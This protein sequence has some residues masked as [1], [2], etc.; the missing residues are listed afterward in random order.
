MLIAEYSNLIRVKELI[1]NSPVHLELLE[2]K[3][4]NL[5]LSSTADQPQGLV[6]FAT[7]P[8]LFCRFLEGLITLQTL[9]NE[10]PSRFVEIISEDKTALYSRHD[11]EVILTSGDKT[12]R[13]LTN[14]CPIEIW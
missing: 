8:A 2:N 9:L 6:Y 12:I 5:F 7:T 14:R 4:G 11:M 13:E 3:E 1:S 10:S